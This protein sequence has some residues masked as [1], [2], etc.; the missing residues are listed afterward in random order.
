MP[1]ILL[2]KIISSYPTQNLISK[3]ILSGGGFRI[4]LDFSRES[5]K[6]IFDRSYILSFF[7]HDSGNE[8]WIGLCLTRLV[9]RTFDLS[10]AWAGRFFCFSEVRKAIM[11][12]RE[13]IIQVRE[14]IIQVRKAIIQVRE[15]IIQVRESIIQ[16]RKAIIQVRKAI[17]QVR[18]A[19]IQ[20]RK[21]IIQVRT[22]C[23]FLCFSC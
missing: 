23:R 22:R 14:A 6:M 15:S 20:V 7:G 16:V 5:S 9:Q 8:Q 4:F 1:S 2:P 10:G 18:K 11:Q 19:I 21:A 3:R 13:S 17:I 12:V